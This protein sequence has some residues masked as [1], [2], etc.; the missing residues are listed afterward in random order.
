[1]VGKERGGI[2]P[3]VTTTKP[4]PVVVFERKNGIEWDFAILREFTTAS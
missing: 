3:V 1:M 4:K 2:A